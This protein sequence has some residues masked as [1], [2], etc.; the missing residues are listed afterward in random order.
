MIY[1]ELAQAAML[2]GSTSQKVCSD[3]GLTLDA[4]LEIFL[5][6]KLCVSNPQLETLGTQRS[7]WSN[8]TADPNL[9]SERQT[10]PLVLLEPTSVWPALHLGRPGFSAFTTE[11][12]GHHR[13]MWLWEHMGCPWTTQHTSS[14][15]L[16]YPRASPP[17]PCSVLLS[18]CP[19]CLSEGNN[20]LGRWLWV[21]AVRLV[22]P[23][24]SFQDSRALESQ[25]LGPLKYSSSLTL[26]SPSSSLVSL[27]AQPYEIYFS[28]AIGMLH[29]HCSLRHHIF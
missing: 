1:S 5:R 23:S 20:S 25:G 2:L 27:R 15:A 18:S 17:P 9:V 11:W 16:F 24:P 12:Q 7:L 4:W 19:K 14:R 22:T 6:V 10:L 21:S 29:N 3:G 28:F 8:T 13:T 26:P